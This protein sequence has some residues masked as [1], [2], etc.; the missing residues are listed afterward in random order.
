[1]DSISI[2]NN[3]TMNKILGYWECL[4]QRTKDLGKLKV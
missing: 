3:E 1:M 4:K 2:L